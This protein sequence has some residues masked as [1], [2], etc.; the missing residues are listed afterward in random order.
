MVLIVRV[1]V[2]STIL[3]VEREPLLPLDRGGWQR[4]IAVDVDL[5]RER[6]RD[7]DH[8]MERDHGLEL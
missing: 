6:S 5:E 2:R 7:R 4:Q 3:L 1:Q 8:G